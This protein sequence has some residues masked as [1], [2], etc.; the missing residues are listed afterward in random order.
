MAKKIIKVISRICTAVFILYGFNLI[1]SSVNIFI[2][3]NI[4]S[5]GLI[6][7][8]G[9]PGYFSLLLMFFITK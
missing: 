6:T 2:P 7:L 1:L 4:I 3:I 5:V 9:F 8:L